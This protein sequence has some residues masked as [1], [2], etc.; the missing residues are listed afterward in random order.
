MKD[1]NIAESDDV[2]GLVY[3]IK[4]KQKTCGMKLFYGSK[5]SLKIPRG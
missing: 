5:K 2:P 3:L 4:K 1:N